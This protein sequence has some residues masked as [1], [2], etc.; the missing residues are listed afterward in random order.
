MNETDRLLNLDQ[1]DTVEVTLGGRSFTLRQ[2]RRAL[3][4]QI[5]TG[6]Q[7]TERQRDDALPPKPDD[8][9][10]TGNL[11]WQEKRTQAFFENWESALPLYALIFS[12]EPKDPEHA[13]VLEHL[14]EHLTFPKAQLI[15][16]RWHQLNQIDR[17]FDLKGSPMVP[18]TTYQNYLEIRKEAIMQFVKDEMQGEVTPAPGESKPS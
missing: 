3:I 12:V 2:Q 16:D 10:V 1:D 11:A 15:Y 17:F 9:D 4:E 5:V 18:E 6:V 14:K 13:S 7:Q 8:D